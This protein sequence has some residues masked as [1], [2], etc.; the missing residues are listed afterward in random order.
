MPKSRGLVHVLTCVTGGKTHIT[1][2]PTY[3]TMLV[4]GAVAGLG[5]ANVCENKDVWG[6]NP[7]HRL[8]QY[9]DYLENASK[10]DQNEVEFWETELSNLLDKIQRE[11]P[12]LTD[13]AI[14]HYLKGNFPRK[15][16]PRVFILSDGLD[17]FFNDVQ[18]VLRRK[19]LFREQEIQRRIDLQ[20]K[21]ILEDMAIEDLEHDVR[22]RI[23]G[24]GILQ[25]SE[26][27]EDLEV[28]S[29]GENK[30]LSEGRKESPPKGRKETARP[31]ESLAV[32][33]GKRRLWIDHAGAQN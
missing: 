20:K 23:V 11:Q 14:T 25:S 6:G 26:G 31:M 32:P 9:I 1:D 10:L 4:S 13:E 16:V 7:V 27:G 24:E 3:K 15:P 8:S 17:V 12:N 19:K 33:N 2:F 18:A 28:G 5:I 30:N 21:K 22:D 29:R